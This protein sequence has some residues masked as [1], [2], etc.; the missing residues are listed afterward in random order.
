MIVCRGIKSQEMAF[1]LC[2]PNEGAARKG[3]KGVEDVGGE[4]DVAWLSRACMGSGEA[5]LAAGLRDCWGVALRPTSL[6]VCEGSM[7]KA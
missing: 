3:R 7:W 2:R 4:V 6:A 1:R 5:A